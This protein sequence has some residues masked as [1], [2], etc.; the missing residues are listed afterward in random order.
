MKAHKGELLAILLRTGVRGTPVMLLAYRTLR[1]VGGMG[2]LAR[3]SVAQLRQLHG[4][5]PEKAATL[6]G[7]LELCRRTGAAVAAEQLPMAPRTGRKVRVR[8]EPLQRAPATSNP[9]LNL[10]NRMSQDARP[11]LPD[12]QYLFLR[13]FASTSNCFL[14]CVKRSCGAARASPRRTAAREKT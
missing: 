9:T 4:V 5:G 10:P 12:S 8:F 13:L 2:G 11:R 7:A 14:K 6:A 1:E 3:A